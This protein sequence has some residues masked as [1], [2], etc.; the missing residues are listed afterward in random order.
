MS[1][2]RLSLGLLAILLSGAAAIARPQAASKPSHY[3]F[4]WARSADTSQPDFLAVID[5]W[6]S[7]PT[8]GH[9]IDSVSTGVPVNLAH[10]TDYAMPAGGILFADDYTSGLTFRFDLRDPRAPKLLGMFGAAGP[11]THPHSYVH[12]PNGHVLATYQMEGAWNDQPGALVELDSE[13][14]LLRSSSAADPSIEK[15]IRPYSLVVVP[16][17]DRV[18]TTSYDMY[19]SDASHVVQVWRLSDLRLIKTIRLPEGPRGVEG[20]DSAEPRLLEDGRTVL[21][22]TF[23]CGLFR[24]TGLDGDNPA[25]EFLYGFGGTVCAVPVVAGHYWIQPVMKVEAQMAVYR[26][27]GKPHP[28]PL[29][30]KSGYHETDAIVALDISN[31]SHPVQAFR[32]ALRAHDYPH[33]LA[34]E[35]DGKR[36]VLTGYEN[37][38]N[39]VVMIDV[40]EKGRLSV[41]RRFHN[42]EAG[43][44]PG[45]RLDAKRWPHG[46]SGAAIP[47]GTVFSLQ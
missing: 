26:F 20:A 33:W 38:L 40:G 44:E 34:L 46:G 5:A 30:P 35:P 17:L 11:Y 8:Y 21:I 14:K 42:R 31:L 12:L 4:A 47:H 27:A 9:V 41:D 10:H 37:L 29:D 23:N 7:S 24:I 13:G 6:P 25:A 16:A 28:V 1:S 36:I 15:F 43:E 3:L 32:L 2:T 19:E 45:I 22:T 39:Q 18:V